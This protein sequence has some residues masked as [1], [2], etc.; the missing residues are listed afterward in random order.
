V[1]L[2]L[3]ALIACKHPAPA[4]V[5]TVVPTA[6]PVA[7]HPAVGDWKGALDLPGGTKLGIVLH[8]RADGDAL[9]ATMDSPDQG[10][11]GIATSAVTFV[12]G[13][14]TVEVAAIGGR[15]EGRLDGPDRWDG[16]WVQ[17]G[18]SMPLAL[19]R[20]A[21]AGPPVRPQDPKPP[22]PYVVEEVSV[23]SVKG[24]VLA[25]TYT[26]P[27]GDGPFPAVVL[28]TGSGPQ[29]R[30][31]ALMG[32]RPFAVLAD[33][34]T[35]AGVAVLRTD[36][37][38]FGK[39][40]GDFQ[41]AITPDFALDAAHA[42][43]WLDAR[44][45]TADVGYIGHSEGGIVAPYAQWKHAD[46]ARADF[47][48]LLAGPSV[49]GQEVIVEQSALIQAATGE[50]MSDADRVAS[51]E[52]FALVAAGGDDLR[53]RALNKLRETP[54]AAALPVAEQE[55]AVDQI[56]SPWFVW[57]LAYEP[58]PALRA[59]DVPVLA[60]FGELDLQVPPTQSAKPMQDALGERGVVEVMPR[61]NHLFQPAKTGS[62][63]EYAQ[64]EATMDLVALARIASFVLERR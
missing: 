59:M 15:Y 23:P 55:A 26:R 6:M 40:T 21:D 33:H 10:A 11:Y 8:V 45:E 16:S 64:I 30:D 42:L 63:T 46:V 31:E 5:H 53:A 4:G 25:G 28:I 36:D 24:V 34:L 7:A 50:P 41:S 19:E 13:Q 44:P 38:G 58:A 27:E 39:S 56:T 12:D 61:L 60:L 9:S 35:R 14:L 62:P 1:R 37:R 47:M 20:T 51:R 22:F 49:N 48:V 18:G 54:E 57:F 32:H 43:A 29:D 17:G 52:L 3:V 2:L